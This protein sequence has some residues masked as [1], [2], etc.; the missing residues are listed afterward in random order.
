[1]ELKEIIDKTLSY[2]Q[3]EKVILYPTDTIWGLGCDA[4][5]PKGIERIQQIKQRPLTKS[6]ILL[7]ASYEMLAQY[8]KVPTEVV[9]FLG[10]Q[11]RPT[12]VIYTEVYDPYLPMAEDHSIAFRVVQD[13][14]CK[15][16]IEAFGRPLVSTSAN[17]SGQ[18]SP[19]SFAEIDPK[20][21]QAVDWVVPYHQEN[22]TP[23]LASQLVMW[24][25]GQ[26]VYIRR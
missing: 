2:L 10:E 13:D 5:S 25:D 14:F 15:Q 11:Q 16:L 22:Q 26:L 8:V 20:V 17:I 6:F 19:T 21:Q 18:P 23:T 9:A 3:Q 4:Y 12:S 24:Q 1:M 7:V